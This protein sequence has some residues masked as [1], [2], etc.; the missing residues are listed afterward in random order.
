ML[1]RGGGKLT[2]QWK[3]WHTRLEWCP[4][5]PPRPSPKL[6]VPAYR[7][8]VVHKARLSPGIA[9]DCK[10]NL[11]LFLN[12][13]DVPTQIT[14]GISC[15]GCWIHAKV[16][17]RPY[18]QPQ[19][20]T[21]THLEQSNLSLNIFSLFVMQ[22]RFTFDNAL[23]NFGSLECNMLQCTM[24][25]LSTKSCLKS[26]KLRPILNGQF[27]HAIWKNIGPNVLGSKQSREILVFVILKL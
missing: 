4:P 16:K 19:L 1:E 6:F 21:V 11:R 3:A 10:L 2:V 9:Q 22:G 12:S 17:D 14:L 26:S 15:C 7:F 25:P 18:M 13:R 23:R 27:C 5:K 24:L 8:W 20:L